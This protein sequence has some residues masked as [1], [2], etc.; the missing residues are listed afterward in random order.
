MV[1]PSPIQAVQRVEGICGLEEPSSSE[2]IHPI[3]RVELGRIV[4]EKLRICE[5][6][7]RQIMEIFVQSSLGDF[8]VGGWWLQLMVNTHGHQGSKNPLCL[9]TNQPLLCSSIHSALRQTPLKLLAI[10]DSPEFALTKDIN[11]LAS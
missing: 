3:A 6:E 2:V 7:V 10:L 1:V 11:F 9:L 5:D 4:L 8:R